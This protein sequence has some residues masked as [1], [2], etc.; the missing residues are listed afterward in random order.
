MAN[1]ELE[2]VIDFQERRRRRH[3]LAICYRDKPKE[4]VIGGLAMPC[5]PP[6]LGGSLHSPFSSR[7]SRI[8][9]K[10]SVTFKIRPAIAVFRHQIDAFINKFFHN[11]PLR[12][13]TPTLWQV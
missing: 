10:R 5:M 7:W 9:T 1:R 6:P 11:I 12:Q 8:A 3:R 2:R 4:L 13:S